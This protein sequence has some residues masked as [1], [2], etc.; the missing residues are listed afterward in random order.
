MSMLTDLRNERWFISSLERGLNVI[1]AFSG[2]KPTLSISE[3]AKHSGTS[4]ASARRIAMTLEALGYLG[5]S[6]GNQ[7]YLTPKTLAL[8]TAY[9][10]SHGVGDALQPILRRLRD[11]SGRSSSISVLDGEEIIYVARASASGPLRVHINVGQRLPA[12]ATAMG[13][14]L[15][16]ALSD[17]DFEAWL[18]DA[19]LEP[20]TEATITDPSKFRAAIE[21]VRADDYC[22]VE[23]ELGPGIKV[24]AVPIVSAQGKTVAALNLTTQS[25]FDRE[26][27]VVAE[28]LPEV[29]R[30]AAEISGVWNHLQVRNARDMLDPGPD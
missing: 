2:A 26:R 4:R 16:A 29:R 21:T 27:D 5:R 23:G 18:R 8:G 14:V 9:L 19:R 7:Y 28:F 30:A 10:S 25:A 1:N 11:M 20:V 6:E 22:V 24:L 13:R 3:I 15:L 17:Q 12:Y